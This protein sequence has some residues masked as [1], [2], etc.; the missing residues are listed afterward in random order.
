MKE[1]FK[2][3]NISYYEEDF[4]DEISDY[5][6]LIPL[7]KDMEDS[8]T[9]EEIQVTD[10]N[11]CCNISKNNIY[12]EIVG[13]LNRDEEFITKEEMVTYNI[14]RAE[15]TLFVITIYKCV[16]CG[17]WLIDILED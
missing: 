13:Y 1:L 11:D 4:F 3:N 15:V 7:I 6:D 5:E 2:I 17:K 10:I 9:S 16:D 8:L 14:D 12:T